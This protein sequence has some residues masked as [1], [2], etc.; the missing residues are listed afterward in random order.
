MLFSVLFSI[1]L[2][3]GGMCA[4]TGL[5]LGSKIVAFVKVKVIPYIKSKF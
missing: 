3:V 2:F 4:E 5:G 1:L